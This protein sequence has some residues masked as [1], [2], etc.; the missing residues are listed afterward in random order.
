MSGR[1]SS[2][3]SAGSAASMGMISPFFR[4][5]GGMPTTM[6]MSLAP[7]STAL[8]QRSEFHVLPRGWTYDG[9]ACR[10]PA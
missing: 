3:R 6:W 7:W 4:I 1:V 9:A 8:Q 10:P 5:M 2:A